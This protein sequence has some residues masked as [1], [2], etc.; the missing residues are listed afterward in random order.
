MEVRR[1][2][3]DWM[4]E[5][6]VSICSIPGDALADIIAD[7][8]VFYHLENWVGSTIDPYTTVYLS[9]IRAFQKHITTAAFKVAGGVD[10][11][12]SSSSSSR[13]RAQNPIANE[14]VT[15]ITKAFL[16]SLYAFLDGLVHLASDES[17]TTANGAR[18]SM[19]AV[20]GTNPLELVKIEEAVS[21]VGQFDSNPILKRSLAGHPCIARCLQLRTSHARPYT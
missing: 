1:P 3:R 5:R 6:F 8:N 18:L 11:S 16:D 13:A 19:P 21:I 12:S 17:P 9:Q 20:P 15:K 7:S 4:V 10:L 2:S 14:F